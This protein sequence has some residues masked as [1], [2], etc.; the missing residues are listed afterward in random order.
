MP[1]ILEKSSRI[2]KKTKYFESV[3][4]LKCFFD[5]KQKITHF[6]TFLDKMK[7]SGIL[8]FETYDWFCAD[9]SHVGN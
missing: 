4:A 5:E 1:Q 8:C 6:L 7:F 2:I 9:M 3:I